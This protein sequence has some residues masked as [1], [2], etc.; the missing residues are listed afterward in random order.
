MTT[1]AHDRAE[2]LD[3]IRTSAWDQGEKCPHCDG[4][5]TIRNG[6]NR[7]V[8]C[9]LG[10]IGA[11]WSEQSAL[12]LI[13]AADEVQ[14]HR[15]LFGVCIA[16]HSEGKWYAFDQLDEQFNDRAPLPTAAAR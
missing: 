13:A 11:D 1:P 5:G 3:A 6:T 9:F 4:A 12:D 16:A 14:W 10:S 2:F 7:T 8:H 15:G